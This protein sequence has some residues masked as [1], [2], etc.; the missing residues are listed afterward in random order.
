MA[1]LIRKNSD[2]KLF[3]MVTRELNRL[4]KGPSY[5]PDLVRDLLKQRKEGERLYARA[6]DITEE[7]MESVKATLYSSEH[8]WNEKEKFSYIYNTH[9][10]RVGGKFLSKVKFKDIL[11]KLGFPVHPSTGNVLTV[12]EL[13]KI[14]EDLLL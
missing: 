14:N 12:F 7:N 8:P 2:P 5:F 11:I 3:A 13:D 1:Y 4:N 6:P 10:D 9:C